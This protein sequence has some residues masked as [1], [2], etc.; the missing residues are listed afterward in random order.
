MKTSKTAIHDF[1][2]VLSGVTEVTE[3]AA[4]ALYEA[5]CDDG[6]F[7]SRDGL[8]FIMFHRQAK[9]LRAAIDSAIA[10]VKSAGF[11]VV[12]V[13][14]DDANT[15]AKV[16]ADL[17]GALELSY[18]RVTA[19][20]KLT[21]QVR[22]RD[23]LLELLARGESPAWVISADREQHLSH[24]QVVNFEGTQM[25]EGVFDRNASVRRDDERL[26]LR[27]LDGRIVNCKVQFDGQNP[28][29]YIADNG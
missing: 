8:A 18:C 9:S 6:S 2:V 19:M 4:N 16:N 25:I 13:E 27:F 5:G 1:T 3:D 15:V 10:D 14:T 24:V 21:V 28:V 20:P 11:G 29:R 12:R 17:L 22:T 23:N 26:V 7:A